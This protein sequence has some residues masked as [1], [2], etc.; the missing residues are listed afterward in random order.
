MKKNERGLYAKYQLINT[1]TIIK[2]RPCF[3]V[4]ATFEGVGWLKFRDGC[5]SSGTWV[6]K[7][8]EM[9]G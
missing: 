2:A 1:L 6:A 7:F 9:G 3:L 4:I 8:W 5:L